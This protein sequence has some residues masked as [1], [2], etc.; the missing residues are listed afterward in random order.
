MALFGITAK[1]WRDQ[2]PDLSGNIRDFAI[3]AQLVCLSNLE[4]LN[5]LF[6]QQK[7]S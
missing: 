1:D 7:L 5:A 3:A 4:T 2:N 6:I